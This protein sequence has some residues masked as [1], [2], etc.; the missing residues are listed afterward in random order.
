MDYEQWLEELE[1]ELWVRLGAQM[2]EFED[3]DFEDFYERGYSYTQIAERLYEDDEDDE[4]EL[5][6]DDDY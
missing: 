1:E 2:D 6:E 3:V 4:D 5:N